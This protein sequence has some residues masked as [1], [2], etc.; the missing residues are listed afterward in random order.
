[1]GGRRLATTLGVLALALAADVGA[2][3]STNIDDYVLF[4]ATTI[5]TRAPT[6]TDGDVGVNEPNGQLV[7]PRSFTAPNSVVAADR[8][9]FDRVAS[10][11]VLQR[12]YANDVQ[13]GPPATPVTLPIIADV[14]AACGYPSPFPVCTPGVDVDVPAGTTTT[15]APGTYGRVRVHGTSIASGALVL[16][17]GSYVFCDLKVSRAAALRAQ[18][19]STIDVVGK[20][21]LGASSYFGPDT[22][23]G[24]V[25][26][27]I[28]MYSAGPT[29]RLSR[30]SVSNARICSP[31][32][33]MKISRGGSH[34]GVYVAA[35]I[36][37]QDV[38]LG[39]GS[40]S[41]A[42]VE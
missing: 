20:V 8:V 1:M 11:T 15:L 3:P 40:P 31:S 18:A 42:F 4:A 6:I 37:T 12:L 33:K 24:L 16:S 28:Q 39:I 41:G 38:A 27:D 32:A 2:Q 7:A 13:F 35:F 25:A 22:G 21:S 9:R 23:S 17:G 14:P 36:R 29:V 30:Q 34:R 26:S 19:P 10:N 5:K